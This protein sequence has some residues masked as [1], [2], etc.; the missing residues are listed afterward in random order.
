MKKIIIL[1]LLIFSI[2]V[3]IPGMVLADVLPYPNPPHPIPV[4]PPTNLLQNEVSRITGTLRQGMKNNTNV[5]VL[6]DYLN[7]MQKANLAEDGNFGNKTRLAV[8]IF[9][10][11][12]SLEP[13]G[14]AGKNTIK[15]MLESL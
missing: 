10:K 7:Q 11:A 9:Q 2:T 3:S 1:F 13:D 14:I 15:K 12:N 8:I 6:Q 5:R 4:P